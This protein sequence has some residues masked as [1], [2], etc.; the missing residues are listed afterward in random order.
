MANSENTSALDVALDLV[1]ALDLYDGL[2]GGDDVTIEVVAQSTNDRES[3]TVTL[4][5]G[6]RY[7]LRVREV[8]DRV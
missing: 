1:A 7:E 4:S 2:F 5:N 3:V 8:L 6:D